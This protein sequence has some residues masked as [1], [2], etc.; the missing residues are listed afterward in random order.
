[1]IPRHYKVMYNNERLITDFLADEVAV[2]IDVE[3]S[4]FD[5]PVER[6]NLSVPVTDPALT[7]YIGEKY[8]NYLWF[9]RFNFTAADFEAQQ[10]IQICR[11]FGLFECRVSLII[12]TCCWKPTATLLFWM[13]L[14]TKRWCHRSG[15]G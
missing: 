1:M 6:G 15:S 13:L 10:L 12:D 9:G 3:Q 4:F 7:A 2:N 8:A 14:V 5:V 11:E